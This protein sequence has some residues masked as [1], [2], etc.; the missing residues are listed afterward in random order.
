MFISLHVLIL[1]ILASLTLALIPGP[2]MLFIMSRTLSDHIRGGLWSVLGI[3]TG[4]LFHTLLVASGVSLIIMHMPVLFHS[5]KL[6][7]AFYLI[8]LGMK[9]LFS[10]SNKPLNSQEVFTQQH[11][12]KL[13]F[14]GLITNLLNPKIIVFFMAFLPQ[15]V[16]PDTS[17]AFLQ[18]LT[19]GLVFIA[20]GTTINSVV[21][22][23]SH[24]LKSWIL[25]NKKFKQIQERIAGLILLA[26][27]IKMVFK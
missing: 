27:G 26:I 4:L 6:A 21:V 19:L 13:F 3:S 15:F 24:R 14:D 7:G 1:F 20:T 23:F 11:S 12:R 16:V 17:P 5:V 8:Y 22:I 18:L 2:D 9:L 25:K 10:K